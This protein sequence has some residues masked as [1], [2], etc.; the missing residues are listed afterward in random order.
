MGPLRREG[1]R[2]CQYTR[3]FAFGTVSRDEAKLTIPL[4]DARGHRKYKELLVA[5]GSVSGVGGGLSN[6]SSG[7]FVVRLTSFSLLKL[8]QKLLLLLGTEVKS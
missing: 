8:S 6:G 2:A 4:E 3:L 7:G 1:A 5:T